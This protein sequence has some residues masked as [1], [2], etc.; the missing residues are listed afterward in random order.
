MVEAGQGALDDQ[1][2]LGVGGDDERLELGHRRRLPDPVELELLGP[3]PQQRFGGQVGLAGPV[4][5]RFEFAPGLVAGVL[6]HGPSADP[7]LAGPGLQP[8]F[9]ELARSQV[10]GDVRPTHPGRTQ[11]G[12]ED[13]AVLAIAPPGGD[14]GEHPG[15]NSGRSLVHAQ[16]PGQF[17]TQSLQMSRRPGPP[18]GIDLFFSHPGRNQ[19][20]RRHLDGILDERS[21]LGLALGPDSDGL[22]GLLVRGKGQGGDGSFGLVIVGL[23]EGVVGPGDDLVVLVID[24]DNVAISHAQ[25]GVAG[26]GVDVEPGV[27]AG[28]A[29]DPAAAADGAIAV[30]QG[31]GVVLPP[32]R[33]V[34]AGPG[35]N[36]GFVEFH[37]SAFR[38]RVS[39][40]LPSR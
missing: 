28:A 32:R 3:H 13:E 20:V 17:Y 12:P 16:Y 9:F 5:K 35:Q 33:R 31:Q 24:G 22:I 6:D 39:R 34:A 25:D 8:V 23:A 10:G 38:L 26:H 7:F 14:G 37:Q 27:D 11:V 1:G 29:P 19:E 36:I 30:D 18:G 40:P 4:V 15:Q 2:S 21:R